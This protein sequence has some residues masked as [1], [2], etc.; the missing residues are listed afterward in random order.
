MSKIKQVFYAPS[1]TTYSS[2]KSSPQSNNMNQKEILKKFIPLVL[3]FLFCIIGALYFLSPY[4]E[5]ETLTVEGSEDV[6]DQQVIDYSGV[7]S[8]DS[9]WATYFNRSQ[10]EEQV[11][12]ELPQV[13]DVT[14]SFSGMNDFTF[15]IEEYETVAY[16]SEEQGYLKVLENGEVLE[17][18]YTTSIGN[19]PVFLSFEEGNALN[20]IITEFEELDPSIQ[21]LISEVEHIESEHNPLLVRAYMNNGNQVLASIPNFSDRLSY[22]PQMV[23]AV[24]GQYGLFDL[25][26]GAFF[27]PFVNND[28]ETEELEENAEIELENEE[29]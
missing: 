26:A 3:F 22:Y 11:T 1:S 13:S 7:R 20:R 8:G 10:I 15:E 9:L 28:P 18:E 12:L 24:E 23:Q 25:E 6:L 16:I 29:E 17:D 27:I 14:L 5:V 19:Q 4:S 21:D 2:G